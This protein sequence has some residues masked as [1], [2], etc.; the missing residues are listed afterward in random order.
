ME[1]ARRWASYPDDMHCEVAGSLLLFDQLVTRS[2]SRVLACCCYRPP[3]RL[4][5]WLFACHCFRRL[6]HA[7]TW[8]VGRERRPST[9][10]CFPPRDS[11]SRLDQL[12]SR[13][14]RR[15]EPPN[16]CENS[17]SYTDVDLPPQKPPRHDRT[18]WHVRE[19]RPEP[20]SRDA[21]RGPPPNSDHV[22]AFLPCMNLFN[23]YIN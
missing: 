5:W 7:W 11:F 21:V 22:N 8:G 18:V 16:G 12:L 2:R 14:L 19:H 10:W 17:L 9:A 20:P 13:C 15:A 3:C 23:L 1:T 6:S 4:C